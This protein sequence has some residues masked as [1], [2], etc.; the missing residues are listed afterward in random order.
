[1]VDIVESKDPDVVARAERAFRFSV[2]PDGAGVPSLQGIPH[3]SIA[4]VELDHDIGYTYPTWF[5]VALAML[6]AYDVIFSRTGRGLRALATSESTAAG[7]L[8]AGCRLQM[9]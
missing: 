9:A 7:Y 4:D 2:T 8:S 1:M 6:V 5:G 3:L